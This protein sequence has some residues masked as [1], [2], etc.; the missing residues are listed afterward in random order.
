MFIR[1]RMDKLWYTIHAVLYN[2]NKQTIII[3]I[4]QCWGKGGI[5]RVH[6]L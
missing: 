3:S 6:T 4:S 2:N 5:K 1:S